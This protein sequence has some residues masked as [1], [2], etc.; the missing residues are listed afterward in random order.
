MTRTIHFDVLGPNRELRR[1]VNSFRRA[2]LTKVM[3][4]LNGIALTALLVMPALALGQFKCESTDVRGV[5]SI[6][7][8]K[9]YLAVWRHSDYQE[10]LDIYA[11]LQ[12]KDE[13]R[14]AHFEDKGISWQSL[15]AIE[16][17][18]VL[19]FRVRSEVGEGWFGATKLFIYDGKMFIDAF[20]SGEI[21]E[22]IDLDGDGYPEVVEFLGDKGRPSGK[23]RVWVWQTERFKLLTTVTASDLYS[24]RLLSMLLKQSRARSRSGAP[25]PKPPT[26]R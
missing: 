18:A 4:K 6:R 2:I 5:A 16:D 1:Y 11:G 8:D 17:S 25:G 15:S 3:C 22:V 23:V 19:G 14:V 7:G 24:P 26:L 20:E 21:A 13:E 12:C 10:T 9:T